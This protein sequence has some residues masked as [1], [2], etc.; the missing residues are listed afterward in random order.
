MS[1]RDNGTIK[2]GDFVLSGDIGAAM[3]DLVG[4]DKADLVKI[5]VLPAAST[6][7]NTPLLEI[8]LQKAK[9]RSLD[10]S[11]SPESS[12]CSF[13]FYYATATVKHRLQSQ[14]STTVKTDTWQRKQ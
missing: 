8:D 11:G 6:G 5:H 13:S 1:V 7:S 12:S 4:F 2:Y 9:I 10:P 3:A 14:N